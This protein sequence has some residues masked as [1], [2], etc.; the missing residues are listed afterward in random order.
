MIKKVTEELESLHP[1]LATRALQD[2]WLN[3]LS[4]GYIQIVRDRIASEDK[5]VKFILKEI[6]VDLI[7]LEN[8]KKKICSVY[9]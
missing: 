7:K 5:T 6:Y 4:R 1:H 9:C 3:D 8:L 2:F